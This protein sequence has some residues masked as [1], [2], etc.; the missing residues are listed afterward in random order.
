M[1][2][3]DSAQG[4]DHRLGQALKEKAPQVRGPGEL[5]GELSLDEF[6]G[7]GTVWRLS[8]TAVTAVRALLL[9]RRR[10]SQFLELFPESEPLL[11][12]GI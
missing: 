5:V 7:G 8:V 10:M 9:T 11:R 3:N 2:R 1:G 12:A 4:W 6:R